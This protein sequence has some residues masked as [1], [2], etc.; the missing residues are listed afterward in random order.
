M[1]LSYW[2]KSH[3]LQNLHFNVLFLSYIA[4]E[5]WIDK[6]YSHGNFLSA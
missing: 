1:Q 3:F 6:C 2:R 5:A 4:R